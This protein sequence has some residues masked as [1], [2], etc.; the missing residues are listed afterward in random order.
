RVRRGRP[1]P[2]ER[3][4][5]ARRR[6]RGTATCGR[7]Y[8]GGRRR[9]AW[10]IVTGRFPHTMLLGRFRSTLPL[11]LV[12]ASLSVALLQPA[13]AGA[14]TAQDARTESFRLQAEGM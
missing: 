8:R 5:K 3:R 13:P 14:I 1:P 7:D 9:G 12:A 2:G 10:A 6:S 11:L 4:V